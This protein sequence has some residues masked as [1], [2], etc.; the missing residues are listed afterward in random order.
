[1]AARRRGYELAR[2]YYL[3]R[4][5]I[6]N[7]REPWERGVRRIRNFTGLFVDTVVS[8]LGEPSVSWA[9][10]DVPHDRAFRDVMELEGGAGFEASAELGIAVDGDG[11]VKVTWDAAEGRV[12]VVRV[13]PAGVYVERLPDGTVA[14]V[15]QQYQLVA[16]EASPAFPAGVGESFGPRGKMTVT[17][18]WTRERWEFWEGEELRLRDANPYRGL[19][20]YVVAANVAVPWQWW[21]ASDVLPLVG[22]QDAMNE[23]ERDL[24]WTM[25]L[26]GSVIV[27]TGADD[28]PLA[29]KPG[30]IWDVPEG[31]TVALLE[32]LGNN[33]VGQRLEDLAHLRDVMHSL[34]RVP[35]VSVGDAGIGSSVSGL[36]LQLQLGPLERLVATKRLTR[37][38]A[39]R[40]RA[41]LVASLG[42]QFG[43]LPEIA[44]LPDV[45]WRDAIPSDRSGDLANAETELR[46]GR[47]AAA[48]L[49][50][51]GVEKPQEELQAR[52]RQ[53]SEGLT[54]PAG[55]MGAMGHGTGTGPAGSAS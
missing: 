50:S 48:V 10:G 14:L 46:L 6:N 42:T 5:R 26:A 51:I 45:S 43:G 3:G 41:R 15:A 30:A 55:S 18:V 24:D 28:G 17:E 49:A 31:A 37:T 9:D 29:V 13:D 21:G 8:Q 1:M 39:L 44:G 53:V 32:L 25:E 47:D 23:R 4:H 19:I 12:R 7:R 27:R 35:H 52:R 2:D 22:L 54:G 16:G 34:S 33:A 11:V 38:A 40:S 36:A 20:P